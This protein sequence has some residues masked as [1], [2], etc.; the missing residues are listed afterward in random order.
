MTV[1][2]FT[3]SANRLTY[4]ADSSTVSYT[5]NFDIADED[6]IEVYVN[7]V[8]KSLTTDYSIT[9]DSGTSG[10]G[11]VVFVSAPAASASIILKR[12]T[13]LIRTT[14]FQTNGSFT[15]SAINNELDR[16]MQSVQEID[17]KVENR[18]L[19]VDHFQTAPTDFTIPTTRS[20]QYLKFDG[21][22][23]ITVTDD[24]TGA[25]ITVTGN[26]SVGGTLSVTGATTLSSISVA[27]PG[28][29]TTSTPHGLSVGDVIRV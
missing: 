6:S 20:N 11:T 13:N 8:L 19:R 26:V 7:N 18:V 15:A 22:G 3:D 27:N 21:S 10:T 2:A 28:V 24:F 1:G 5:F 17:D 12:D 29:F 23:N 9:F 16:L 4:V 14:D 25:D